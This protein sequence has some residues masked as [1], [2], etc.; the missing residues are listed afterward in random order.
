[1]VGVQPHVDTRAA[2]LPSARELER[3]FDGS[4]GQPR[5]PPS[6]TSTVTLVIFAFL[7]SFASSLGRL[8]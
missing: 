8:R 3:S 6:R 2:G 4:G 7:F 5:S 1:M